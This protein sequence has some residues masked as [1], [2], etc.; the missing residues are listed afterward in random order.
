MLC[1]TPEDLILSG[2]FEMF[3]GKD[4]IV[5][6]RSSGKLNAVTTLSPIGVAGDPITTRW[7]GNALI[8]NGYR[9]S[10]TNNEYMNIDCNDNN[11]IRITQG[12]EMEKIVRSVAELIAVIKGKRTNVE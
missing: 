8:R 7:V 9:P 2:A 3:F 12:N 1:G 11:Q 4:G 6:D 5:F 10:E